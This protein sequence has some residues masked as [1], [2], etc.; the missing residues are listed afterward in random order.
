MPL[1]LKIGGPRAGYGW[2]VPSLAL[3]DDT[4][5]YFE[6]RGSG[7]PVLLLAPGGMRSG[8]DLWANAAVDPWASYA[9]DF[10]LIAMDQRNTGRSRGPLDPADPWGSYAADQLAVLDHLGVD[11][12]L[13]MG[14]CI[15]GS[16]IL[17]LV[18]QVPERVV[19]AVLEQPIGVHPANRDLFTAMGRSWADDLLAG[20]PDLDAA[21]VDRFLAAMWRDE[22]VVSVSRDV[23]AR[24]P[25]PL[26][27]LPG[28]DDYHPTEAGRRVAALAP[29]AEVLEPWKD[30]AEHIAAATGAVRE[31]L[32]G[33]AGRV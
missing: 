17:K 10:R 16:F 13:V 22:F 8:I 5:I 12:F 19:A 20:R 15:G 25:V 14:C 4:T 9:G 6:E 18:E 33:H 11:R 28:V 1:C 30:S 7:V 31:F 24:C 21:T 23:I 29:H 2:P 27:V 32:L 3:D 26:L